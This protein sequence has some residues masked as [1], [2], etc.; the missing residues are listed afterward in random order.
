[1]IRDLWEHNR[2]ALL[3]FAVALVALG[4]FGVR[5]FASAVYWY[6]PAHQDQPLAPWMTPRYVAKSYD[7]PPSIMRE[8]LMLAPDGPPRR[9][10]LDRLA[11]E[12]GV[13][14]EV[15]QA[16]VEAAA[17]ILDAQREAEK[18][19]RANDE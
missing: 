7:L 5:T 9:I 10:R 6:D 19:H 3:A 8:A 16:R 4:V 13:T 17:E 11:L 2:P 1:M 15:L 14:L 12:K 18:L